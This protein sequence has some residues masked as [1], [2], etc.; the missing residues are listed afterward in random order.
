MLNITIHTEWYSRPFLR[1]WRV[2]VSLTPVITISDRLHLPA[3]SR[4][5]KFLQFSRAR[6]T[7]L[8]MRMS[9]SACLHTCRTNPGTSLRSASIPF[10]NKVPGPSAWLLVYC[11]PAYLF[12]WARVQKDIFL[13]KDRWRNGYMCTFRLQSSS[14]PRECPKY[15]KSIHLLLIC[16]CRSR[17]IW[18]LLMSIVGLK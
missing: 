6:A 15:K 8:S 5:M 11:F 13:V 1:Y 14:H 2:S 7:S 3:T 12:T 18:K 17:R 16:K 10:T 4:R 9:Y